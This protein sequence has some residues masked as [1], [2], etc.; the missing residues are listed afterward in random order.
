MTR[1]DKKKESKEFSRVVESFAANN[2]MTLI[3]AILEHCSRIKMETEVAV[4]LITP[5]L[6]KKIQ[7]QAMASNQLKAKKSRGLPI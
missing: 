7:L 4:K 2:N 5:Q 6:K 1:I 3:E